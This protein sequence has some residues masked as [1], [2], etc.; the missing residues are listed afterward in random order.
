MREFLKSLTKFEIGLILSICLINVYLGIVDGS[1]DFIGLTACITGVICVVMTAK[2]H[3]SC[4][5]FGLVNI[6]AYVYIAYISKFYGEVMLN[7][8]YYLP[9]QFIGIYL[10]KKNMNEGDNI[11]KGK[12]MTIKQIILLVLTSIVSICIYSLV[13]QKLHGNLPII[14]ATSTV[15]SVFAMYLSVK[16]YAEQWLLWIVVNV[17]T[18]IMWTFAFI[19][20]DANS[21]AMIVMWSAYLLNAIHGY[22]NWKKLAN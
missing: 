8:L 17:V 21:V 16:R 6:L 1:N 14:D 18:I 10:W 4:Y 5:Y 2:G 11:V 20:G 22:I 15:L 19:N 13:L 3:I 9:M 7:G 12:T